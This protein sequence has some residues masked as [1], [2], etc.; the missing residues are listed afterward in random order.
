MASAGPRRST[1]APHWSSRVCRRGDWYGCLRL[2]VAVMPAA[3]SDRDYNGEWA[4]WWEQALIWT[5][6]WTDANLPT[7]AS[8]DARVLAGLRGAWSRPRHRPP[9]SQCVGRIEARSGYFQSLLDWP[10]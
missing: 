2:F 7:I 3:G 4:G 9:R 8:A 5:V 10:F 1:S 6:D